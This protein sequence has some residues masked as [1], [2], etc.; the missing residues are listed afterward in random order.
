M[1]KQKATF[2]F[3]GIALALAWPITDAP[4]SAQT[5]S[6]SEARKA[7]LTVRALSFNRRSGDRGGSTT[8]IDL[9][10]GAAV[11]IY[12]TT[13]ALAQSRGTV[14]GFPWRS[15]ELCGTALSSTARGRRGPL[16]VSN[17]RYSWQLD[18]KML[19]V[20][21]DKITFDVA[22]ARTHRAE[23]MEIVRNTFHLTLRE[24]EPRIIDLV[25][26][27]PSSACDTVFIELSASV[28]EEP[29]ASR[30]SIDWD[31]WLNNGRAPGV[32]QRHVITRHGEAGPFD[33]D[34]IKTTAVTLDKETEEAYVQLT[35]QV[36]GRVRPDGSIDVALST[37]RSVVFDPTVRANPLGLRN[38]GPGGGGSG[39]KNFIMKP[40]EA[41]KIVLPPTG[42]YPGYVPPPESEISITV[43]A[44]LR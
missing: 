2:L 25:H 24:D 20:E 23:P 12:A 9:A 5:L 15:D 35:G 32:A 37:T 22:L 7:T 34:A 1:L 8:Y 41:V 42:G 14:G 43:A 16:D 27:S 13:G 40:G 11:E 33:F 29:A 31:L 39:Q 36:R 3:G 17:A 38:A 44:R 10:A 18:V 6:I 19:S 26:G 30:S 28:A 4:T 21:T